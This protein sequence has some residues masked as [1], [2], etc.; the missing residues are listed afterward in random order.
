VEAC[1][2]ARATSPGRMCTSPAVYIGLVKDYANSLK[3]QGFKNVFIVGDSGGNTRPDSTAAAELQK[4]WAG[5]GAKA[6]Y[7]PEFYDY[8]EILTY[9][10]EHMSTPETRYSDRF[11]DNYYITT[12]IMV[13]NPEAANYSG[14]VKIGETKTNGFSIYPVEKA[15]WHGRQ[16]IEFRTDATVAAIKKD[17]GQTS[18]SSK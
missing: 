8:D 6:F 10:N 12:M 9:E 15:Q 13:G 16:L 4:E 3:A 11:H 1:D 18:T 14:R 5:S 7:I 2:P 17:L